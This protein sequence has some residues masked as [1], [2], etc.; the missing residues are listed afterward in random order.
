MSR[1]A[2]FRMRPAELFI[3]K[4]R[5]E[6]IKLSPAVQEQLHNAQLHNASKKTVRQDEFSL[7]DEK[8]LKK[9]KKLKKKKGDDATRNSDEDNDNGEKF[10]QLYGVAI[11]LA[12]TKISTKSKSNPIKMRSIFA[13]QSHCREPKTLSTR[14][15]KHKLPLCKDNLRSASKSLWT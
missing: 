3:P 9:S 15:Y 6:T 13:R 2:R 10:E 8:V 12:M 4:Q 7:Q 5:R 1:Q 11:S 14:R